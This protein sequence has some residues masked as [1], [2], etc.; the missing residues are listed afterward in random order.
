MT[1]QEHVTNLTNLVIK[2]ELE[3]DKLQARLE[4]EVIDHNTTLQ[5]LDIAKE[6]LEKVQMASFNKDMDAYI[7]ETLEKLK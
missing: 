4:M 3:I 1:E 6:A 5:K 2:R 7:D